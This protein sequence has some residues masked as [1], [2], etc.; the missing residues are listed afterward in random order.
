[1]ATETGRR[2]ETGEEYID[3]NIST[4]EKPGDE[5]ENMKYKCLLMDNAYNRLEMYLGNNYAECTTHH[6]KA[7]NHESVRCLPIQAKA[8]M[9]CHPCVGLK[10]FPVS[11]V[12]DEP[13]LCRGELTKHHKFLG[14]VRS[15]VLCKNKNCITAE[16][17]KASDL[18]AWS[19][20]SK[21]VNIDKKPN[22]KHRKSICCSEFL[23]G[24]AHGYRGNGEGDVEHVCSMGSNGALLMYAMKHVISD[25]NLGGNRQPVASD[26]L[27]AI[28]EDGQLS[29]SSQ[30]SLSSMASKSDNESVRHDDLP[31]IKPPFIEPS[32]T[33]KFLAG[34]IKCHIPENDSLTMSVEDFQEAL[35][36]FV[37]DLKVLYRELLRN[38]TGFVNSVHCIQVEILAHMGETK[39][40]DHP[41]HSDINPQHA[42]LLTACQNDTEPT[43]AVRCNPNFAP[44]DT[45][46][47]LEC[48]DRQHNLVHDAKA[49]FFLRRLL[50]LKTQPVLKEYY[51]GNQEILA[52]SSTLIFPCFQLDQSVWKYTKRSDTHVIETCCKC[53]R[54]SQCLN[55]C[56]C[57]EKQRLC[58]SCQS[59]CCCNTLDY[60]N[61]IDEESAKRSQIKKVNGRIRTLTAKLEKKPPSSTAALSSLTETI[62]SNQIQL[63]KLTEELT[64]IVRRKEDYKSNRSADVK[65]QDSAASNSAYVQYG[66]FQLQL[67][68][69]IVIPGNCL[70]YGKPRSNQVLVSMTVSP[71]PEYPESYASYGLSTF[72]MFMEDMWN[73][74][75]PEL[76]EKW[77]KTLLRWCSFYLVLELCS[78]TKCTTRLSV[79][80]HL[81][82][83]ISTIEDH[84]FSLAYPP[85]VK[86]PTLKSKDKF[87]P[88]EYTVDLPFKLPLSAKECFDPEKP[89]PI[90]TSNKK[91]NGDSGYADAKREVREE[92]R[93]QFK[94]KHNIALAMRYVYDFLVYKGAHKN[95]ELLEQV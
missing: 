8:F 20:Y 75:R 42:N 80:T 74:I 6:D 84:F 3:R 40:G 31:E 32:S 13:V 21:A 94:L 5:W 65:D 64:P 39:A 19:E 24:L 53:S 52:Q 73:I 55:S 58:T 66:E 9:I 70:H 90:F 14:F 95:D 71:K 81:T 44:K 83:L 87:V 43:R 15:M 86:K 38:R 30:V 62:A 7:H 60:N 51:S 34:L 56:Q 93:N 45:E 33:T 85:I 77:R 37:G 22:T 88:E 11:R 4:L 78:Q 2:P 69:T 41:Q 1:V 68:D 50:P 36:A 26:D 46:S 47:L 54:G 48:M 49:P 76:E 89:H 16:K 57:R 23:T 72:M 61:I 91:K 63:A 67:G 25:T 17:L 18:E 28:D 10:R 79:S 35:L 27:P 92:R 12:L 82:L 29:V 59:R